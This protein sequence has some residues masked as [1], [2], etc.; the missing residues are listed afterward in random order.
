ML[1]LEIGYQRYA[2]FLKYQ[3]LRR[4]PFATRTIE[5]V[6]VIPTPN[7][8]VGRRGGAWDVEVEL[9]ADLGPVH[10]RATNVPIE[11]LVGRVPHE[12][13][14]CRGPSSVRRE[15]GSAVRLGALDDFPQRGRGM[16]PFSCMSHQM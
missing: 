16:S 3:V 10:V 5:R 4:Q 1:G 11:V 7:D 15:R 6:G 8:I 13:S 12:E 14:E 9:F 2:G